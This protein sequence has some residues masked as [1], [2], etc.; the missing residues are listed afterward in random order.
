MMTWLIDF[1]LIAIASLL[2]WV[3]GGIVIIEAII[4]ANRPWRSRPSGPWRR[5]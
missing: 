5:R 4:L 3:I 1:A 2:V